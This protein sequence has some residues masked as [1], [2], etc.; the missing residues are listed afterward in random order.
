MKMIYYQSEK[1]YIS[2]MLFIKEYEKVVYTFEKGFIWSFAS[3]IECKKYNRTCDSDLWKVE[4]IFNQSIGNRPSIKQYIKMQKIMTKLTNIKL[5]SL[6]KSDNLRDNYTL[7]RRITL[8]VEKLGD[9]TREAEFDV[10]TKRGVSYTSET[11]AIMEAIILKLEVINLQMDSYL[12][13][14]MII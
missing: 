14:I 7:G 3:H 1:Y 6:I 13:H 9:L 12:S 11:K 2:T 4:P 5:H 8:L 10:E